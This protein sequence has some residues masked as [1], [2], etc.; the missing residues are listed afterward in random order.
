[1]PGT[2]RA[3]GPL[4]GFD[5]CTERTN[6]TPRNAN[7]GLSPP[8]RLICSLLS[9]FYSLEGPLEH[10]ARAGEEHGAVAVELGIW[11]RS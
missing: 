9:T 1:M 11:D 2:Q 8:A 7:R 3:N 10:G 6:G 4:F 5:D